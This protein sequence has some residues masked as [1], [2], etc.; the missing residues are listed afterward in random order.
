MATE[1]R[2]SLLLTF[3]K[4]GE[5]E[6]FLRI[7]TVN[8]KDH[9]LCDDIAFDLGPMLREGVMLSVQCES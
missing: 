2:G 9:K 1:Y 6:S 4:D 7:P 3:H 8:A 5:S